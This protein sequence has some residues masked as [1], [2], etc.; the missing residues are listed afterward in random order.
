MLWVCHGSSLHTLPPTGLGSDHLTLWHSLVTENPALLWA[1][2]CR[3]SG[4]VTCL[5]PPQPPWPHMTSALPT[6]GPSFPPTLPPSYSSDLR[7]LGFF[8]VLFP[9]PQTA[10]C[11][12]CYSSYLLY[13]TATWVLFG[14]KY[15]NL[16][17][18]I[19]NWIT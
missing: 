14:P 8:T 7:A 11:I 16:Q 5:W 10:L 13:S 1:D 6:S 19:L 9:A 3:G 2:Q 4:A 18:G 12:H 15:R 17:S